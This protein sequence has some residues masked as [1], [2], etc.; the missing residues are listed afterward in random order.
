MRT[1]QI[2]R[3]ISWSALT[4]LFGLFLTVGATAAPAT[5]SA[6]ESASAS[7]V[8]NLFT[9]TETGTGYTVNS[10][11]SW[12]DLTAVEAYADAPNGKVLHSV[13]DNS[14]STSEVWPNIILNLPYEAEAT[15]FAGYVMWIEYSG[16]VY[17]NDSYWSIFQFATNGKVI[18]YNAPITFIDSNGKIDETKSGGYQHHRNNMTAL[19]DNKG[20]T[21]AYE[22]SFKGYV[23]M[24]KESF[25]STDGLAPK[26]DGTVKFN[27]D[28]RNVFDIDLKIGEIGYYTDYNAVLNEYGRCNYSFVD[29][30]GTVIQSDSVKPNTPITAPD[31]KNTYAKNGKVYE[32]VGWSNY[33]EGMTLTAD[34]TFN[35][36]YKVRDF[37]M[38]KGASIRTTEGSSGIR[39]IAEF[40]ENLYNEV[41]LDDN[42]QFGMLITKYD[43]YTAALESSEDLIDGLNSL[44]ANK[45]ALITQSSN[46][47][48]KPY[49]TVTETNVRYRINGAITNITYAHADWKWI[50]VGVVITQTSEGAEYL[51]CAFN[52]E[53]VARTASYV[54]SAAL[55]NPEEKFNET[56]TATVKNYVY[57]TAAKLADVTEADFNATADKSVYLQGYSLEINGG[58]D[59]S[60]KFNMNID[61]KEA[62]LTIGE[63][64][65]VS[66]QV[67]NANGGVLDVAY[68]LSVAD[69]DVLDVNGTTVTALK[70]GYSAL[71]MS[72]E[73]FGYSEEIMVYTGSTDAGNR[74]NGV[75]GSN[76]NASGI[77]A[78]TSEI[79][80]VP[81]YWYQYSTAAGGSA[82]IYASYP[83]DMSVY[84]IDYLISQGYKYLRVPFYFDTTRWAE[85]GATSA[86]QVTTPYITTWIAKQFK[87]AG[88]SDGSGYNKN[89]PANEWCYFDMDLTLYRMNFVEATGAGADTY[90]MK[91]K[92][93]SYY[94]YLIM[95]FCSAYSYVY[96]GQHTFIK[97]S[98]VS[99]DESNDSVSFGDTVNFADYYATDVAVKYTVNGAEMDSMVA[100]SATNEVTISANVFTTNIG[101]AGNQYVIGNTDSWK[102]TYTTFAPVQKTLTVEGGVEDLAGGKEILVDVK[103]GA[104][105][106]T[107]AYTKADVLKSLE[108]FTVTETYV[109]RYS[110]GSV[111]TSS[112]IPANERGIFY[113]TVNASNG[114]QSFEYTTTLD[115][116]S[117]LEPIEYE[118]FGHADSSY[119]VKAWYYLNGALT[120]KS[121]DELVSTY[122]SEA[123]E[124]MPITV[125]DG[126]ASLMHYGDH[127][128]DNSANVKNAYGYDSADSIYYFAIDQSKIGPDSPLVHEVGNST[129]AINIYV[130]PRHSKAYYEYFAEIN[131][132]KLKYAYAAGWSKGQS[133]RYSIVDIVSEVKAD[134][135][136]KDYWSAD[137]Q[138]TF[139]TDLQAITLSTIVQYYDSFNSNVYPFYVSEDPHGRTSTDLNNGVM[140]LSSLLF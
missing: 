113:V 60:K 90:G 31:Y 46:N 58:L 84:Y 125:G 140:K 120:S 8:V 132:G 52:A 33:T 88:A 102:V 41:T 10:L 77:K 11:S 35:A 135:R 136:Y 63:A 130:L 23:V 54:A 74:A 48:V 121:Y 24:P 53:D 65:G 7:T 86:D 36:S 69:E 128:K 32:L 75:H 61:G 25:N 1:K 30:D 98:T 18:T 70:N 9:P 85:L 112:T 73:L 47:P 16:T 138:H 127:S 37:Q 64:N 119:A 99:I 76:V 45:Y 109:K 13:I 87:T 44:G 126:Y 82:H 111:V 124:G 59:T 22:Y 67:V 129:T 57:K 100:L 28:Y 116:Y 5:A 19:E 6:D 104:D 80:G 83:K 26:A 72:C 103:D 20:Y 27:W 15:D 51:Y 117:S 56:Q 34:T 71:T 107:A 123:G 97:E 21:Y 39:F 95:K 55:N 114:V 94:Q 17:S 4:A 68:T 131:T 137:W 115:L 43:Y 42:K 38:V 29:Y 66:A 62:Y 101:T 2:L 93:S 3:K 122:T 91:L 133:K 92:S 106:I 134:V 79:D 110:D 49:K 139:T 14:E 108:G 105:V 118:S 12:S 89:V 50:G 81:Y 78:E 96:T 40:D